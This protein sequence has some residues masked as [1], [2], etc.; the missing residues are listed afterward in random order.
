[1]SVYLSVFEDLTYNGPAIKGVCVPA[2][3]P[4]KRD[5]ALFAVMV[6]ILLSIMS[7]APAPLMQNKSG[8]TSFLSGRELIPVDEFGKRHKCSIAVQTITEPVIYHGIGF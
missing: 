4:K 3:F 2:F 7:V 1:M 5:S 6:Q 8:A